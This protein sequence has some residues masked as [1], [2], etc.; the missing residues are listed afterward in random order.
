MDTYD[1]SNERI[2]KRETLTVSAGE[3]KN[4][5]INIYNEIK[6]T[7][8]H[9]DAQLPVNAHD[10]DAGYDLVAIDDG[11]IVC[12]K[13]KNILYIQY[14]TGIAIEP[15]KGFHT[16]IFPRSSVTKTHLVLGNSI[17]LIDTSYRGEI[18]VRFKV[19]NLPDVNYYPIV[20]K[21]DVKNK[22]IEMYKKGDKIAQ[23]VIRPT[24]NMSFSWVDKLEET[25]RGDGGFGSTDLIK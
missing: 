23:L 22:S 21:M 9:P 15:P 13:D 8:L 17:G 24:F 25:K 1:F 7:K 4:F 5:V 14:K 19:V 10:G 20:D 2:E 6:V 18:M 3:Y 12:D 11:E 16:E